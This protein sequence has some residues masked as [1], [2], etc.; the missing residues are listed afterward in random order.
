MRY[1]AAAAARQKPGLDPI[2]FAQ[3]WSSDVGTAIQSRR[4]C[5]ALSVLPKAHDSEEWLISGDRH[6]LP[7]R[8]W[9]EDGEHD[10]WAPR[11]TQTFEDDPPADCGSEP[12]AA[13]DV[14]VRTT[15]HA[16][17]PP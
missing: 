4:A 15:L 1:A 5:M 8:F 7:P 11:Y 17:M 2:G 9:A 16:L 6:V 14:C 10:T 12:P 13:G 3:R